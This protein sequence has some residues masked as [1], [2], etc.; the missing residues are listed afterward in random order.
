[1]RAIAISS[2]LALALLLAPA[3][4]EKKDAAAAAKPEAAAAAEGAAKEGAAKEGAAKEGA[5]KEGAAKEGAAEEGAAAGGDDAAT[6]D[7]C[8]KAFDNLLT[9]MGKEGAPAAIVAQMTGQRDKTIAECVKETKAQPDGNKALDCMTAAQSQ[10]D[11][12]ACTQKYAKSN[13]NAGKPAPAA[14]APAGAAPAGAAPAGAAPS[15]AAPAAAAPAAA[16]PEAAAPAAEET[17]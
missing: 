6:A 7:R 11:I 14:A 13:P 15:A 10:A 9:I 17:E 2:F 16:A 4:G 5:A 1:M 12:V 8:G 3:C